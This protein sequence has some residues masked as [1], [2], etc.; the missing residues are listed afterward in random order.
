MPVFVVVTVTQIV[1]WTS[2]LPTAK[3]KY[4]FSNIITDFHLRG[5]GSLQYSIEN[6]VA[7]AAALLGR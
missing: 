4:T 1:E 7:T 6:S 5:I 3:Y 2:G